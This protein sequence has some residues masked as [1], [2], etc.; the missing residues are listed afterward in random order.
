MGGALLVPS[1]H[2]RYVAGCAEGTSL[3]RPQEVQG[4]ALH[5]SCWPMAGCKT[6]ERCRSG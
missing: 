3:I 1:T 2:H 4:S 5:A 6:Q